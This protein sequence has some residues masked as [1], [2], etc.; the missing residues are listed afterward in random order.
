[1]KGHADELLGAGIEIEDR[2]GARGVDTGRVVDVVAAH[3]GE[4][5]FCGSDFAEAQDCLCY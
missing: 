4:I 5:G 3:D 1:V 2:A